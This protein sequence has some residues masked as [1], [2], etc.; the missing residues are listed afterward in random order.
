M[1]RPYSQCCGSTPTWSR[2]GSAARGRPVFLGDPGACTI[3]QERSWGGGRGRDTSGHARHPPP[4][5]RYGFAIK[6][7]P[8]GGKPFGDEEDDEQNEQP[9]GTEEEAL[10]G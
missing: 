2:R 3:V 5:T 8:K 7:F 9:E 4:V 1:R 6:A 10:E